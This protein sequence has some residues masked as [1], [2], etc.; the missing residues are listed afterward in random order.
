MQEDNVWTKA[1]HVRL[2]VDLPPVSESA[3]KELDDREFAIGQGCSE[4]EK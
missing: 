1:I 2:G 4:L 3:V